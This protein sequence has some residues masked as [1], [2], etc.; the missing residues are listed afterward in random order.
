[1]KEESVS[2]VLWSVIASGAKQSSIFT[3]QKVASVVPP[4]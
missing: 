2:K 4:S 3:N 1:L